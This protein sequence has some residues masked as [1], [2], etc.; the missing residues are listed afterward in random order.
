MKLLVTVDSRVRLRIGDSAALLL[1]EVVLAELRSLFEHPNPEYAKKRRMRFSTKGEP[2]FIRT[3]HE[4]GRG[5]ERVLSLPRGGL[6][7]V[8]NVL[9]KH[10]VEWRAVDERTEGDAALAGQVP[11]H[12]LPLY[13]YQEHAV[14][15]AIEKQNCLVRAPTGC[16]TGDTLVGINRAGKGSQMRLDHVVRMFNGGSSHG[17]TWRSD[18]PTFVR[19][20]CEDGVVRL[21]RLLGATE[22]GKREVFTLS[23]DGLQVRGTC[24]HRVLT[25]LGWVP[26]GEL[27]VGDYVLVEDTRRP[28]PKDGPK[29]K[30]QYHVRVLREHPYA[31]RWG[32]HWSKGGGSV[33]VHRLVAEARLNGMGLEEFVAAVKQRSSGLRFL[34]PREWAVHHGDRNSRNNNPENLHVLTHSEHKAEHK[35]ES[36]ASLEVR[37]VPRRVIDVSYYGVEDTYDLE[38]ETAHAFVANGA[39]VHNSGKTCAALALVARVNLPAIVVVWSGNLFDQWVA[40]CEKELGIPSRDVGRVRGSKRDVRPVTV[41][42]QQSIA[43]DPRWAAQHRDTF[44]VVLCD[45]V[46]RFAARTLFASVDPFRAKYRIGI[47]A[48]ESRKDRKEFL[49]YD[50]FGTVAAD[51]DQREL[52]E[53]GHVHDVA[54][55]VVPTEFKAPWYRERQDFKK[56][57]DEMTADPLR[58]SIALHLAQEQAAQGHQVIVWSHRRGHCHTLDA[59][60]AKWGVMSGLLIGGDDYKDRFDETRFGLEQHTL[61]AGVGTLQAVGQALD[62]PMLARGVL[63]TPLAGNRQQ[64]GQARGRLCRTARDEGKLDAE[65]YYLW[66]RHVYGRGHLRNLVKW[67]GPAVTVWNGSDWADGRRYLATMR[68]DDAATEAASMEGIFQ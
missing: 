27:R 38:V 8:R 44:G 28:V 59:G 34:D 62:I 7:R 40:R 9:R 49:I 5:G 47:S 20:P 23:L 66:D 60:L 41:A 25:P 63:T 58:N 46:Q 21:C 12:R 24:D 65:L 16:L 13:G 2:P 56:L 4:E 26:L 22:S 11:P 39:A 64:F 6:Q 29:S 54:I 53:S 67:Y 18:I 55:R 45:E 30:P 43:S 19:A 61:M 52:I 50:L 68:D 51:I 37:L 42:M 1:P 17:R 10:G 35:D 57:L 31:G 32:V 36:V 15:A 48:D 3:W 14:Q 33:P